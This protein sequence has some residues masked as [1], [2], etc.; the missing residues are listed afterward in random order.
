MKNTE[1]SLLVS[2]ISGQSSKDLDK[3]ISSVLDQNS[4]DG[5]FSDPAIARV[6]QEVLRGMFTP[7]LISKCLPTVA[8]AKKFQDFERLTMCVVK[9]YE[10]MD[11]ILDDLRNGQRSRQAEIFTR[12]TE[13][14]LNK[15]A[16]SLNDKFYYKTDIS[17]VLDDIFFE[18]E[19]LIAAQESLRPELEDQEKLRSQ[20]LKSAQ[21][22]KKMYNRKA[23]DCGISKLAELTKLGIS[24]LISKTDLGDRCVFD[25]IN[26]ETNIRQM[27]KNAV[28]RTDLHND[29]Y[30]F[31]YLNDK[32]KIKHFVFFKIILIEVVQDKMAQKTE[33]VHFEQNPTQSE[34]RSVMYEQFYLENSENATLQIDSSYENIIEVEYEDDINLYNIQSKLIM[35]M[36]KII[37]KSFVKDKLPTDHFKRSQSDIPQ[38]IFTMEDLYDLFSF[39]KG[40][41]PSAMYDENKLKMLESTMTHGVVGDAYTSSRYPGD[42]GSAV[43]V[44]NTS[45]VHQELLDLHGGIGKKYDGSLQH[46]RGN[47][48]NGNDSRALGTYSSNVPKS[49]L[50]SVIAA[51]QKKLE[52]SQVIDNVKNFAGEQYGSNLS[53]SGQHSVKDYER[54]RAEQ[55]NRRKEEEMA[56]QQ[57]EKEAREER[58]RERKLMAD[59][60]RERR[61]QEAREREAR[62][63]KQRHEADERRRQLEDERAERDRK[64]REEKEARDKVENEKREN[65][66]V[67]R[68]V[69]EKLEN[70]RKEKDR[71]EREERAKE[72]KEK[73]DRERLERE[74]REKIERD[75]RIKEEQERRDRDRIER[76]AREK[77]ERDRREKDREEREAKEKIERDRRDQ[78]RIEREE[79]DRVLRE[80][81]DQESK[82][83]SEREKK[84]REER[85]R[86]E[87]EKREKEAKDREE[88]DRLEQ[89]RR[90][91]KEKQRI[92]REALL[93]KQ[94]EEDERQRQK[95]EKEEQEEREKQKAE[96]KLKSEQAKAVK[97]DDGDDFDDFD[98]FGDI[99]DGLDDFGGSVGKKKTEEKVEDVLKGD[100]RD[101]DEILGG[102][103]GSVEKKKSEEKIDDILD[104]DFGDID[105]DIDFGG[106]VEKK[107]P[108]VETVDD[109]LRDELEGSL[110]KKKSIIQKSDEKLNDGDDFDDFDDFD[111]ELDDFAASTEKKKEIAPPSEQIKAEPLKPATS[112]VKKNDAADEAIEFDDEDD[113]DDILNDDLEESKPKSSKKSPIVAQPS[114]DPEP[115]PTPEKDPPVTAFAGGLRGLKKR[116]DERHQAPAESHA[117]NQHLELD[118][119][120]NHTKLVKHDQLPVV[121][122]YLQRASPL[123]E[124]QVQDFM[125]SLVLDNGSVSMIFNEFISNQTIFLLDFEETNHIL[126]LWVDALQNNGQLDD[127]SINQLGRMIGQLLQGTFEDQPFDKIK[128]FF[129]PFMVVGELGQESLAQAIVDLR[130]KQVFFVSLNPDMS[131]EAIRKDVSFHTVANILAKCLNVAMGGDIKIQISSDNLHAPAMGIELIEFLAESCDAPPPEEGEEDGEGPEP[132]YPYLRFM[133]ISYLILYENATDRLNFDGFKKSLSLEAFDLMNAA[134]FVSTM[135]AAGDSLR[136]RTQ[137]QQMPEIAEGLL[138]TAQQIKIH[139]NCE[140]LPKLAETLT[141]PAEL[142]EVIK[143]DIAELTEIGKSADR[144]LSVLE[145]MFNEES[146]QKIVLFLAL[147]K[148][149]PNL[150]M[151]LS[152]N[153]EPFNSQALAVVKSE[154]KASSGSYPDIFIENA[155]HQFATDKI[156]IFCFTWSIMIYEEQLSAV[157]ALRCMMYNETPFVNELMQ[158]MMAGEEEMNPNDMAMG[159][160]DSN[161]RGIVEDPNGGI[162]GDEDDNFDD[163]G[164]DDFDDDFADEKPKAAAAPPKKASGAKLRSNPPKQSNIDYNFDEDEDFDIDGDQAAGGKKDDNAGGGDFDD[165]DDDDFDF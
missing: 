13:Q 154:L 123:N 70:E 158:G 38:V 165:I 122:D 162:V 147:Q 3:I 99:D 65:E 6:Y 27:I 31:F 58:E 43:N 90:D 35:A 152:D 14:I 40:G 23:I 100:F 26:F 121:D 137:L 142:N 97:I 130:N 44:I 59:A 140:I 32:R 87:H 95:K 118:N 28:Q 93:K 52:Q 64:L 75:T 143:A 19:N 104:D 5:A 15:T 146:T 91:E 16:D 20:S 53:R 114:K 46:S 102:A 54:E 80:K 157:D 2:A 127:G 134:R 79:R 110:E 9:M 47:Y 125:G 45:E 117:S 50:Q 68:E 71:I 151:Y 156:D 111:D 30:V 37:Y 113:F 101:I 124:D 148:D 96:E 61:E 74:D 72:L 12:L 77:E 48:L 86:I 150:L 24:R 63:E 106:S 129:A 42:R 112:I 25:W 81:Q 78:E 18:I 164:L 126:R 160:E 139:K 73:M 107:K 105:D 161:E 8:N 98:D 36:Y 131:E 56:R 153:T 141:N 66:R 163:F 149:E 76:E 17:K 11:R 33:I 109:A 29:K 145:Y 120:Q 39:L 88:R 103:E 57:R 21:F 41:S 155:R 138:E 108:V 159:Q 92:A 144:V 84:D 89:E 115:E 82:D 116:S 83:R 10:T 94:Q 4:K 62:L 22:E 51:N 1:E 60:E 85:E 49:F 136:L 69:R 34:K 133:M 119:P 132:S 128:Y 67:E 135:R 7:E 55:Q